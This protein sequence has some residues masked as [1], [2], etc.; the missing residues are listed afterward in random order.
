MSSPSNGFEIDAKSFT[1]FQKRLRGFDG[2]I[3]RELNKKVRQLAA[4]IVADVQ[5][6]ALRLPS[7]GGDL[8]GDKRWKQKK[9]TVGLRQGMAHA[10]EFRM[11]Y[12]KNGA[13]A[14]IRISGTKFQAATGKYKKIPRYVEGMGRKPWRHPVF[15][16]KGSTNGSWDGP[17]T[18][19]KSTPFLLPT[20]MRQKD[21]VRTAIVNVFI[22]EVNRQLVSGNLSLFK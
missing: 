1:E 4:P 8:E 17:W 19:Q 9:F 16:D 5:R 3:A 21:A 11:F 20:V 15:A 13:R 12:Q 14:R 6:A 22:D 18:E 2:K 7:T 10:T